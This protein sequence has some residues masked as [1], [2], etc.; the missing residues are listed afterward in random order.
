MEHLSE[1]QQKIVDLKKKKNAIIL[2]HYYQE[3]D[4]QQ[5]ADFV[6]DSLGL[7]QEAAKTE[8]DIIV[9]AGVH[10]MAE[11]ASILNP[12]KKVIL[13]DLEASCSLA[14][15]C[16]PDEFKSFID[17]HPDHK[18]VTYINCSAEIKAMSDVICTSANAVDVIRSFDIDEKIICA[19]DK[20][21][22][23]Y[24][25]NQTGHDLVI[26]DG[27]CD[28]H[29]AFSWEKIDK[30]KKQYPNSVFIAHP[31][32]TND[33]LSKADFIGSTSAM[34]RF[35]KE[36]KAS[37]IIVATEAG[38]L[39][40]MQKVVPNKTLIAAPAFENNICACSECS[41]MKKNTL[42]KLYTSLLNEFPEI[43]VD[44][45]IRLKAIKPIKRMLEFSN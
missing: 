33:I 19:P 34:I 6:G 24:I 5:I 12:T 43:K 7:S 18:V 28:V 15:S 37:E 32:S 39:Y 38:I 17:D 30:L 11:T 23:K 3:P 20:N 9:F 14:E 26:W 40:E 13:P 29:E 1:L 22:A 10:F 36:S 16:P 31:E 45:A 21:L 35:V 8:S 42:E 2:A 41:Y 4:I 27:A 44:E 25:S